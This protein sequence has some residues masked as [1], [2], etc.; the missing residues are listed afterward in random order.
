M[1]TRLVDPVRN[2][3]A[4]D[5]GRRAPS[6]AEALLDLTQGQQAAVGRED[7]T[8][9]RAMIGLLATGNSP[10]WGG[11]QLRA[12]DTVSGNGGVLGSQPNR[13]EDHGS[14]LCP[15]APVDVPR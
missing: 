13:I 4:A 1:S 9:K 14:M 8:T 6:D 15:S 7:A 11:A 5:T 2:V 10:S 3:R 12:A